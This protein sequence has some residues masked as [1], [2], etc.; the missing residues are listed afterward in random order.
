MMRLSNAMSP[1]L[2]RAKRLASALLPNS[3]RKLDIRQLWKFHESMDYCLMA[4][5]HLHSQMIEVA[6]P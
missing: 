1:S 6:L 5:H 4:A 3:A 2:N